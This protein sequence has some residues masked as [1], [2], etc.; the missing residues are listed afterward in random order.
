[1][2]ERFHTLKEIAELTGLKYWLVLRC[3]NNGLF[4]TYTVGNKRKRALLSEVLT[5]I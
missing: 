5:A 4:P 2:T 3:A 1:M